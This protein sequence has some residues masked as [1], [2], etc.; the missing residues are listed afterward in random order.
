MKRRLVLG[1]TYVLLVVVVGLAVPFAITLGRRLTQE[2]GTRVER[3]AFAVAAALEDA[4]E[5]QA[6]AGIQ[7]QTGDFASR[8][9]GRVVVTG[10]DGTLLGDSLEPPGAQPPSYATRPEIARAL[11]GEPTWARRHSATLGED[12]LVSAVPVSSGGR[13]LGAVRISYPMS[14]VQ[15]SIRRTYLFLA[16]VGSLAVAA[17]LLLA[18]GLA[19]WATRPLEAAAAAAR[20][21]AGGDLETLVPVEGPAEVRQLATDMNSMTARLGDLLRANR[22][23]AADASHQLRTPLTALRLSLE[24]AAAGDGR[25]ENLS[26]ALEQTSRLERTVTALLALGSGDGRGAG[27]VDLRRA[28]TEALASLPPGVP[29]DV[30]GSGHAVADEERVRQSLVN[31]LDNARRFARTRVLVSIDRRETLT[32][33]AVEDD[34]PGVRDADR[35]RVFDRFF[36]AGPGEG[37]GLGLAVVRE[38]ARRDRADV[39]VGRSRWGGARFEIAYPAAAA[40]DSSSPVENRS[41]T[42]RTVRM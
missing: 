19:R 42:P 32:V 9:G 5:H 31:L 39:T 13:I 24:N 37:A 30:V 16:G 29:V 21:I 15:A 26:Y 2:L 23:F 28:A 10:P 41:P 34:G 12:L 22:E 25:D 7:A 27:S 11:E 3:E 38:L 17:G 4:L 14:E 8:I 36:H 6:V 35:L 33:A 20:Q 1:A 40:L 18:A